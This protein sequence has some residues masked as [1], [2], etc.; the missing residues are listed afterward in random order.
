MESV[1]HFQRLTTVR[2]VWFDCWDLKFSVLGIGGVQTLV[3]WSIVTY[4]CGL[5][6][7]A[8]YYLI[9]SLQP[10]LPWTVCNPY[11][12]GKD[13]HTSDLDL[14]NFRDYSCKKNLTSS[15]EQYFL[16]VL[17]VS[18]MSLALCILE[19]LMQ[20]VRA[21][22]GGNAVSWNK[23]SRLAFGNVFSFSVVFDFSSPGEKC[24]RVWETFLLH[25]F[26]SLLRSSGSIPSSHHFRRCRRR[27]SLFPETSVEQTS[28]R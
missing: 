5:M 16:W 12:D 18:L 20:E 23:Q 8:F 27:Y 4:H 1:A 11:W 7:I 28:P 6:A 9:Q 2:T 24:N 22:S 21:A 25:R 14:K 17:H 13:C 26:V 15:A 10:V 3:S 19:V